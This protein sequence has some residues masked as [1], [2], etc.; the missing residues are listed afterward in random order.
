MMEIESRS[1]IGAARIGTSG[2]QYDHWRGV[3]YPRNM[4]K[5][6]WFTHYARSFDTVEINN[7]FYRLPQEHTFTVWKEKAPPGFCYALKYSRY[8]THVKRL[9]EPEKVIDNFLA[10]AERLEE[11]LG[12]ILVQLPPKWHADA[13]RLDN[14]LQQTPAVHRWAIE[15]RD[16]SWLNR[17]IFDLLRQYGA[18][19][20]IHDMIPDHPFVITTD[21]VYFRF[22]GTNYG[23]GYPIEKLEAIADRMAKCRR[24]N[25]DVYGYFNNDVGGHAVRNALDLKRL[26]SERL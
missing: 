20:C 5:K 16:P 1:A 4:P 13:E 17:E 11:L 23:E 9:R 26:L 10:R 7:T 2:F 14:F 8:G 21:W 3:L 18:A 12:P 24:D 19:L 22:H 15:F 25:L 6:D